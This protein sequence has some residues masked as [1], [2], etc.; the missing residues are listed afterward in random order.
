MSKIAVNSI[1]G[2]LEPIKQHRCLYYAENNMSI[3]IIAMLIE[4]YL[5]TWSLKSIWRDVLQISNLRHIT[6]YFVI[7]ADTPAVILH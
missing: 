3:D 1:S 7:Y 6:H 2:H 5:Y 4:A